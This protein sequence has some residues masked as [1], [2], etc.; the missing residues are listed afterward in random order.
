MPSKTTDIDMMESKSCFF[1][2]CQN[3]SN[4]EVELRPRNFSQSSLGI[5]PVPCASPR[6][7]KEDERKRWGALGRVKVRNTELVCLK[8][9][10]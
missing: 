3:L 2:G 6:Y 7:D 9:A 8:I 10:G 5:R 1:R 4:L